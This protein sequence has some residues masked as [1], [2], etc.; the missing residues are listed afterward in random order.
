M[1]FK[2]E[3]IILVLLVLSILTSI[4]SSLSA[5]EDE[6]Y[7]PDIIGEYEDATNI[8]FRGSSSKVLEKEKKD[9]VNIDEI[10]STMWMMLI[11]FFFLVVVAT[12]ASLYKLPPHVLILLIAI[13]ILLFGMFFTLVGN[14]DNFFSRMIMPK[15][16]W[17][18]I[19][20]DTFDI[21][22]M[23]D[24]ELKEEKEISRIVDEY[25][26]LPDDEWNETIVEAKTYS[27]EQ[28]SNR[29]AFVFEFNNRQDMDFFISKYITPVR[30]LYVNEETVY[31]ITSDTF[32]KDYYNDAFYFSEDRFLFIVLGEEQYAE[33]AMEKIIN[34]Y[35]EEDVVEN[36]DTTVPEIIAINPL[37]NAFHATK[38][39]KF[40]VKDDSSI[41]MNSIEIENDNSFDPFID[42]KR[43]NKGYEC[44]YLMKKIDEGLNSYVVTAQDKKGNEMTRTIYF[45]KDSTPPNIEEISVIDYSYLREDYITFVIKD[46]D[47]GIKLEES[48]I[49]ISGT[50][51]PIKQYCSVDN[52]K[53]SLCNIDIRNLAKE[54]VNKIILKVKDAAGN[55]QNVM[56]TF[57]RDTIAPEI[58]FIEPSP[59][60][61]YMKKNKIQFRI[62]DTT[63]DI[64]TDSI[65]VSGIFG[66][67]SFEQD[68]YEISNREYFCEF[69]SAPIQGTNTLF[70]ES[71]DGANNLGSDF[72]NFVY[73]T[74]TP[75][76]RLTSSRITKNKIV[77]FELYD[78][79]SPIDLDYNNITGLNGFISLRD[80]CVASE[81]RL[82]CSVISEIKQGYNP[83][84]IQIRDMAENYAI[85]QENIIYDI[86][87]PKINN[88]EYDTQT[89]LVTFEV[90][91]DWG[92]DLTSISV[93]GANGFD[94]EDHCSE[95]EQKV[96][97]LFCSYV[98]LEVI[99]NTISVQASD[100]AQNQ[101]L[102][103][104]VI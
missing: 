40:Q 75:I 54:G 82:S 51:K 70:I 36:I 58:K 14:N 9:G 66:F 35:P 92:I 5:E 24:M 71:E 93:S 21:G 85:Y 4:Q 69:I 72:V 23:E 48:T 60:K 53:E 98:A 46:S 83:I 30:R 25:M 73:D 49:T 80:N 12:L 29:R 1:K 15:D 87:T 88:L 65:I 47:S 57:N 28:N 77:N 101:V 17:T 96:N 31:E 3:V 44:K 33:N 64:K 50:L 56:R 42:C 55:T 95:S 104:I 91:D 18:N 90:F 86:F 32:T 76:I 52:K 2:K 84:R 43:I 89:K 81:K 16:P 79:V 78:L 13:V 41:N 10:Q 100:N 45:Y 20:I 63:S 26:K 27:W 38:E 7:Q 102:E 8:S 74:S 34:K 22:N 68:C 99:G 67:N 61:S 37:D 19:T 103:T 6:E 11:A 59:D 97:T 62:K 39:V 94:R